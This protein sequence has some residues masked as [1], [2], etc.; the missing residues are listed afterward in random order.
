MT[1]LEKAA[2]AVTDLRING[3]SQR[4]R[5]LAAKG[6]WPDR[7]WQP[8]DEQIARAVLMAV[9]AS[10]SDSV[11]DRHVVRAWIDAILRDHPLKGSGES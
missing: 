7:N 1:A 9:R 4:D 3:R 6:L 2:R 8:S 5:V 11:V 10:A